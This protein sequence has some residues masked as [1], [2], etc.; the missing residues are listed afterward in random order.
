M[1][2]AHRYSDFFHAPGNYL[3]RSSTYSR[4][5]RQKEHG[6]HEKKRKGYETW[7][8]FDSF[9]NPNLQMNGVFPG[10]SQELFLQKRNHEAQII[11]WY[12]FTI[13]K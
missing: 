1:F 6:S 10:I 5:Q 2:Y 4:R 7:C 13:V 8:F 9:K 11:C 3:F 12:L